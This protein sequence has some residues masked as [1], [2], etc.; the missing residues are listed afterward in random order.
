MLNICAR[1][2]SRDIKK[3]EENRIN[4]Y[5]QLLVFFSACPHILTFF[6]ENP[7][8]YISSHDKD[9]GWI[10]HLGSS[11][12]CVRGNNRLSEIP[13]YYEPIRSRAAVHEIMN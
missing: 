7:I 6:L 11:V 3:R 5:R 10:K 9:N 4:Y 12:F 2:G 13:H 8:G 1:A